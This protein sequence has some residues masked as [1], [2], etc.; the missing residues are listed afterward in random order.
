[1]KNRDRVIRMI[2]RLKQSVGIDASQSISAEAFASFE[3]RIIDLI[4]ERDREN[5]NLV[6]SLEISSEEIQKYV[7]DQ[8]KQELINIQTSKMAA[9]GEMASSI[10]HEIN[11]PLQI[12]QL[13]ADSMKL[14]E[15]EEA[16]YS[17]DVRKQIEKISITV[18]RVS[19]IILSLRRLSH[20][21]SNH[22]LEFVD[23]KDVVGEVINLCEQKF[24]NSRVNLECDCSGEQIEVEAN[25]QQLSMVMMNLLSN[26][27][28]AVFDLE[29][30][31]K[32]IL[33]K[34]RRLD[35]QNYIQVSNG[36]EKIPED[37]QTKI[38]E[39]FFTT[40]EVGKGT[41]IGLSI[42]R[43]VIDGFGGRIELLSNSE[44]TT[45]QIV[46]PKMK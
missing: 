4:I 28:D 38:F 27:F 3:E 21:K 44:N 19:K 39:S 42:C 36:G 41:G 31:E 15:T 45:F 11:N 17:P 9:I 29:E 33:V 43:K 40:K 10:S 13:A 26:A 2:N 12:I 14:R 5:Q 24:K 30:E 34:L 1:M 37:L 8:K 18:K 16:P 6:R 32:W 46:F 35:D 20:E 25:F 23:M 22:D 7:D